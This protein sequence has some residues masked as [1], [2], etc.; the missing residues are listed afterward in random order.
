[1]SS[2][3]DPLPLPAIT[4]YEGTGSIPGSSPK[5]GPSL[6]QGLFTRYGF[7]PSAT[8]S[9]PSIEALG[10]PNEPVLLTLPIKR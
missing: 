7:R 1:M 9:G 2:G 3:N 6:A 8:K 10:E 5:R 4:R